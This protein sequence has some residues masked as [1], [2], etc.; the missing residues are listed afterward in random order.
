[1]STAPSVA[2]EQTRR[3]SPHVTDEPRPTRAPAPRA[4]RPAPS[5]RNKPR[6]QVGGFGESLQPAAEAA[7]QGCREVQ[8]QP[9]APEAELIG[10]RSSSPMRIGGRLV[11]PNNATATSG[12]HS[13]GARRVWPKLNKIGLRRDGGTCRD[14]VEHRQVHAPRIRS[15][16]IGAIV[17]FSRFRPWPSV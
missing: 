7:G 6:P 3:Q 2:D 12:M 17:R 14:Q 15:C 9:P 13:A 1:M 10:S 8:R 5:Q 4:C 11:M 16:L